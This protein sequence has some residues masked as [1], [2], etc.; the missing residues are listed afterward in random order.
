MKPDVA[1]IGPG[2]VGQTLGRLLFQA[3]YP[4]VAVSGLREESARAAVAFIGSGQ[5]LPAIPAAE[6]AELILVTTPDRAIPY[7]EAALVYSR[8]RPGAVVAHTSGLLS[9]RVLEYVRNGPGHPA[10]ASA[11]PLQSFARPEEAV[12]RL[13]GVTWALEGDERAL[14]VLEQ[15]V[16]DLGGRPVRISTDGKPLYHAAASVASNFLVALLGAA[17]RLGE[18]AGLPRE[19]VV[20]ALLPLVQGTLA[21][22]ARLGPVE[23]LTGP[24]ARGDVS[25][26]AAHLGAIR[27]SLPDL[28]P[29]YLAMGRETLSVARRKA[30]FPHE[31]A[32]ELERLLGRG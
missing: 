25:T 19:E 5:V 21:N 13:A 2:R 32:P 29:L 31:A 18:S 16:L 6:S 7:V 26:V 11:H 14:A 20:P 28:E 27:A 3:G 9:S 22:V 10:I 8:L 1:I 12:E 17:V 4:V 24:I 23:A 30:S 15:V